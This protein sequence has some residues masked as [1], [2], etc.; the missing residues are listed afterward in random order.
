MVCLVSW[1]CCV[2]D[3][4]L[5]ARLFEGFWNHHCSPLWHG[6]SHAS[7]TGH[8]SCWM[9]GGQ[10]SVGTASGNWTSCKARKPLR[11]FLEGW[12]P[13]VGGASESDWLS[14]DEETVW[15]WRQFH[16]VQDDKSGAQ[17][18]TNSQGPMGSERAEQIKG[19][20]WCWAQG[21]GQTVL[22][23]VTQAL[24]AHTLPI[25]S[26]WPSILLKV[27][28]FFTLKKKIPVPTRGRP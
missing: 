1:Q 16:E 25:P 23:P 6:N 27:G 9:T 11:P 4:H 21:Q 12:V 22:G 13:R 26:Q 2:L 7:L 10:Q 5:R 15:R 17:E 24:P 14:G 8:H 18:T 19:K 28:Q 20:E 3:A